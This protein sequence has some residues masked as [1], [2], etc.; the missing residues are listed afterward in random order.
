MKKAIILA[1]ILSMLCTC[2]LPVFATEKN[3]L[4]DFLQEVS[5]DSIK[6]IEYHEDGSITVVT[7]EIIAE[8]RA[9]NTKTAKK[10]KTVYSNSGAMFFSVTNTTT[11]TYTGSSS[12]CTSVSAS[13]SVSDTSWTVTT[14]TIISGRTGHVYYSAKQYVSGNLFNTKTDYVSITC[15]STGVIS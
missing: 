15:S 10:T 14:S 8:S 3:M 13:K 6:D 12:S 1:L 9:T 7:L 5:A 11:F 2:I 4:P